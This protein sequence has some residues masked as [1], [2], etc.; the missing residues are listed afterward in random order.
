MG[1][2]KLVNGT[3]PPIK[4]A[5]SY[6]EPKGLAEV[7]DDLIQL[8]GIVLTLIK[9]AEEQIPNEIHKATSIFLMATAGK[10]LLFILD[11]H[12]TVTI[13]YIRALC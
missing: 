7:A 6:K 9:K 10:Y 13:I 5:Y 11:M 12:T 4:C 8:R 3:I 1:D 2:D